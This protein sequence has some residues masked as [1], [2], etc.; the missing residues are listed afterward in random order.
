VCVNKA[1][2]HKTIQSTV[3]ATFVAHKEVVYRPENS[4]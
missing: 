1:I 4:F 2:Y 3:I